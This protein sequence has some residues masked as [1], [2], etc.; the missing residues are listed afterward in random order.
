MYGD[1]EERFAQPRTLRRLVKSGHYGRKSGRG[2][3]DY[4][5]EQP[6]ALD[7]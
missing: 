1:G 7:P 6:V 3:N 4:S 2:F 5:G